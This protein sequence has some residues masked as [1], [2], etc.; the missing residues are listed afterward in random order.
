[1]SVADRAGHGLIVQKAALCAEGM[2]NYASAKGCITLATC[3]G[4]PFMIHP[5]DESLSKY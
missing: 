1:M 4:G 3:T 2:E 5:P